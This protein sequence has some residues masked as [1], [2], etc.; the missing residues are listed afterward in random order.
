MNFMRKKLEVSRNL[1]NVMILI[2]YEPMKCFSF[3]PEGDGQA[4]GRS[5]RYH[6]IDFSLPPVFYKEVCI[7]VN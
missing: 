1:S 3:K 6:L 4:V 5:I 7:D 2:N